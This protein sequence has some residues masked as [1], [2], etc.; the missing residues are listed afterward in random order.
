MYKEK[1]HTNIT[2]EKSSKT[3]SKMLNL[4]NLNTNI[5]NYLKYKGIKYHIM[6]NSKFNNLEYKDIY[7]DKCQTLPSSPRDKKK[8]EDIKSHLMNKNNS[9]YN[10]MMGNDK[11]D[12]LFFGY[13]KSMSQKVNND[14]KINYSPIENHRRSFNNS[15]KYNLALK[16]IEND[17]NKYNKYKKERQNYFNSFDNELK[18]EVT[19]SKNNSYDNVSIKLI[20]NTIPINLQNEPNLKTFKNNE[21]FLSD[22]KIKIIKFIEHISLLLKRDKQNF[23][24]ILKKKRNN[25]GIL[26]IKN[27]YK[28]IIKDKINKSNN[29][30]DFL[31][32]NC[33]TSYENDENN[34]I[35]QNYDIKESLELIEK[36]KTFSN[37]ESVNTESFSFR[38]RKYRNLDKNEL[39]KYKRLYNQSLDLLKKMQCREKNFGFLFIR[40]KVIN[41]K[42]PSKIITSF[43]KIEIDFP[44]EGDFEINSIKKNLEIEKLINDFNIY[45]IK[46]NPYLLSNSPFFIKDSILKYC[47]KLYSEFFFINLKKFS[48]KNTRNKILKKII[49]RYKWKKLQRYFRKFYFRILLSQ[50]IYERNI[51]RENNL[52]SNNVIEFKIENSIYDISVITQSFNDFSFLKSSNK[53]NN[54]STKEIKNKMKLD[55]I[56]RPRKIRYKYLNSIS[57]IRNNLMKSLHK[58]EKIKRMLKYIDKKDPRNASMSSKRLFRPIKVVKKLYDNVTGKFYQYDDFKHSFLKG[59]DNKSSTDN[60]NSV[61]DFYN[62]N[63]I[64]DEKLM[65]LKKVLDYN[66][67]SHSFKVWKYQTK[68]NKKHK[69][70]DIII[71]MMKCF[72]AKNK[73]VKKAFM[74]ET[75]FILGK[76][77]FIWYWKTI[78]QRKKNE[79]KKKIKK[80]MCFK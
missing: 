35:K 68:K 61:E 5:M 79:K 25:E 8:K 71:I 12:I 41:F 80:K 44:E 24:K 53:K 72:F 74:G 3:P 76:N 77:I 73:I 70:N 21:K 45:G 19:K 38:G 34:G 39:K 2:L 28:P 67:F 4:S 32:N 50:Y 54:T 56:Q 65:K 9:N 31:S 22:K 13:N 33:I 58:N 60:K 6:T 17:K 63:Y 29:S 18:K 11:Q 43:R 40:K 55:Y 78:G 52:K 20:Q 30:L 36:I 1:D 46:K 48:I 26:N 57:K 64:I 7:D 37:I 49:Y 15:P 69:F 62:E 14:L 51:E 27:N 10:T 59:S 75:Y 42:I 66:Q 47:Y 16:L 23:L